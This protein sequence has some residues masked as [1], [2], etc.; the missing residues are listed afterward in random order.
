MRF[1]LIFLLSPNPLWKKLLL[2]IHPH[3]VGIAWKLGIAKLSSIIFFQKH[4][5]NSAN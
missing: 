1:L 3:T 5:P 4:L 2:F